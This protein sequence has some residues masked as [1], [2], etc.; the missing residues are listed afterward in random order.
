MCGNADEKVCVCVCADCRAVGMKRG[1]L[2]GA[3]L[4]VSGSIA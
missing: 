3:I 1:V 2:S 4:A